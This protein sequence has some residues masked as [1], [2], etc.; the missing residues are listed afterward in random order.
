MKKPQAKLIGEDGNIFNLMAIASRVLKKAKK[1][2]EDK[3]MQKEI[4]E[5]QSYEEALMKI[6]EYVEIV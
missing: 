2:E 1:L 5:C 3:K 4:W 6:S